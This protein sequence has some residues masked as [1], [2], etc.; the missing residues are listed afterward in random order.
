[1]YITDSHTSQ[2][3]NQGK[4]CMWT[5]TSS[6]QRIGMNA[7]RELLGSKGFSCV[8]PALHCKGYEKTGSVAVSLSA[9][10]K[11]PFFSKKKIWKRT[12]G[13]DLP[14]KGKDSVQHLRERQ[15]RDFS[16]WKETPNQG[17]SRVQNQ[18]LS[19]PAK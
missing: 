12:Y 8:P 5:T 17:G 3:F 10:P 14:G 11:K 4:S 9:T 1:M 13:Q 16:K 6:R 19:L 7:A 18:A 15:S 2:K